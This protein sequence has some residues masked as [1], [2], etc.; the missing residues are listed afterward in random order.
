MGWVDD[1][2]ST[3]VGKVVPIFPHPQ[4]V[5]ARKL[6]LLVMRST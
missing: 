2:D 1:R 4:A 6:A 3:F 5:C